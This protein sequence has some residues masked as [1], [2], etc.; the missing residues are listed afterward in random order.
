[1]LKEKESVINCARI[2]PWM[3]SVGTIR[4]YKVL[5]SDYFSVDKQA[6]E[7]SKIIVRV[8]HYLI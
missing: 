7:K 8:H 3:P 6:P 5:A 2:D 4:F 1:M